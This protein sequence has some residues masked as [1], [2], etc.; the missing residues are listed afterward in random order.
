MLAESRQPKGVSMR[1]KTLSILIAIALMAAVAFQ[2][3]LA[4]FALADYT[5]NDTHG[6]GNG[7]VNALVYDSARDILYRGMGGR[8]VWKLQGGAWAN[9]GGQ[10][11][12][13]TVSSL[14]YDSVN[15]I[16]YGG[17]QEHG[18]WRYNA[19]DP[20]PTWVDISGSLSSYYNSSIILGA[21][22]LYAGIE[23]FNTAEGG[24]WRCTNPTG[25]SPSWEDT[26]GGIG[27]HW[28]SELTYDTANNRLYANAFGVWRY[29]AGDPI[30]S[31]SDI[32]GA[33]SSHYVDAL[34][35]KDGN[36]F[37]GVS[38]GDYIPSG[39]YRCMD[40]G[41]P[42]PTW[43]ATGGSVSSSWIE[44]LQFIGSTLYAGNIGPIASV[45][46]W[47][48]ANPTGSAPLDW[49]YT[50][51][52]SG[53]VNSMA[54]AGGTLYAGAADSPSEENSGVW[55]S[56]NPGVPSPSWNFTGGAASDM[57][58]ES[59]VFDSTRNILYASTWGDGV[60]RYT[61]GSPTPTWSRLG[62]V[63][64]PGSLAYDRVRNILY[65]SL[66]SRCL[67]PNEPGATFEDMG[68]PHGSHYYIGYLA[69]D[70][71]NNVLYG[72]INREDYSE[73]EAH[74]V[75][76]C[77]NPNTSNT[78]FDMGGPGPWPPSGWYS[79]NNKIVCAG[80]SIYVGTDRHGVYKC[81]NPMSATP[82]WA[83]TGGGISGYEVDAIEFD[84][85]SNMLYAGVKDSG[86]SGHG[87]WRYN[88]GGPTPTWVNTN[89]GLS[90]NEIWSLELTGG[91]LYAG[92]RE[93][94]VWRC[95][96]PGGATPVWENTNGELVSKSIWA[97]CYGNG[98]LFAGT[99]V[100]GGG[101]G[102]WQSGDVSPIET[103]TI[104]NIAPNPAQ[105]GQEVTIDGTGF[106]T[107]GAG[108]FVTFHSGLVPTSYNAWGVTQIKVNV[109][110]GAAS[111]TVMV[112]TPG[113]ASTP[114]YLT[115][116]QPHIPAP[117]IASISPTFGPPGTTV[118][119]TGT[120]FGSSR[121]AGKGKSGKGASCVTFNGV[122]ATEYPKWTD[123]EIVCVVPQGA[124]HGPVVVVTGAGSSSSDKTFTVSYPTWYLAEG[125]TDWGYDCY[126]TIENPNTTSVN[127]KLTYQT[128]SGEV[129][130]PHFPMAA[131]SQATVNPR[132]TVG[133]TD[134]STKVECTDGKTIAADRTMTWTGPGAA[135]PEAHNS[136]GVTS[137][138]KTWYLA[139]GSSSWGFE[140]WLLIQNPNASEAT[141]TVTYMIEG[142]GPQTVNKQVNP[143]SRATFDMSKDIGQKDASIKV[144]SDV[145]V[146]PERAMYRNNRREGH[147][148][149]GTTTPASDYYL[150]E[151]ATGYNVGYITYVL[152]QNPNDTPTDVTLTY[153]T[154][155]GQVPGPSFQMP[156][157]SR[158]TIRVND[159]LPPNTDVSTSAHGSAPIIAERAMYWDNGTGEA[160]HDSIGMAE[161]HTSF[162][163]PDGQSSEGR[164]TWTLVQN[165]NDSDVSV[166]I[167]YLTPN[168]QGNVT[169]TEPIGAKSRR[170][171][172]MADKGINGRAAIMV[173]STPAGKKIMVE[174]AMYWNS[175]GAGTDTIGGYED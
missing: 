61:A 151:G 54:V 20:S 126:I 80:G 107:G 28:V 52:P 117:T 172:N 22:I 69:Y 79:W 82:T 138:E 91:V 108:S 139:E 104:T 29:N 57:S 162:Y 132:D 16:V 10:I 134:F 81:P 75:Y 123:T 147:D 125:S 25:A 145:P 46:V 74:G 64:W 111:G 87:V 12:D 141:C 83:D 8:G 40:P 71:A 164:E 53:F 37:A 170:T 93:H 109:P 70:E 127:V 168:G 136:I 122:A 142:S 97:L 89:G 95:T 60:W 158:K 92:V 38:T 124:T 120:G 5:W 102:V 76:R 77:N 144:T 173:T 58:V 155:A 21:G 88:A 67:N 27:A 62:G 65:A 39:V 133:N 4:P 165:P 116:T 166:Q 47:R 100:Y 171:F 121:G 103:P 2:V 63:A 150:A 118:T 13:Y 72:G 137:P 135:S 130:G 56:D 36:L 66:G 68:A 41:D 140:C 105:P 98:T 85:S 157:N 159:Q 14:A 26:N 143:N 23:D 33:I 175:R 6:P 78:W 90:G 17:T 18:V 44:S 59:L 101:Q 152:V 161:P 128:K 35:F 24:V 174:R 50:G 131:S 48:C 11:S 115:I 30:P 86:G 51:G 153:M 96:S 73:P 146:I 9:T 112:T 19:G 32:G 119:I 169:W 114:Y 156:A 113:G 149:I 163:L 110:D 129:A 3:L 99:G 84:A 43:E 154:Q 160:C 34:I 148:S 106:G 45:G 42:S 167:S 15:N 94:G 49:Q 31:W 55:R 7:T 1:V